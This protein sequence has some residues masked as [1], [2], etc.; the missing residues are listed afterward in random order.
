MT[1][2]A[3]VY[4][5]DVATYWNTERNPVNLRL[6]DV[7]GIYHH[8]Y[9]IGEVD[10]SV[11]ETPEDA[12]EQ[13]IIAELHRLENAQARFLLEHLGDIRPDHRLLD[14]GSGRGGSSIMANAA[15]GCQVDGVSISQAQVDFANEQAAKRGVSDRVRFHFRNMLDTG[16]EAGAFQA[17]WNNESTMYTVLDDLFAAHSRLL[18]RGGRYVTITGCYNDVYGLP[19]RAVSTINAHYVCDIHP[20][21]AYFRAM[22]A[23]RLVPVAVVD[24]TPDTIPYWELREKSSVATGIESAFLE[25]YRDGSFQ[26]LLIA[27][28][29]I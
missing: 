5:H 29:R 1:A 10:W 3:S 8:H 13:A 19:S 23:N 22:A 26:Y 28:D 27:A 21:S 6:G 17:V 15:F 25:A 14:A 16:F 7:S 4:Q 20:R 24:L 2:I 12:R 11:L 18:A 9:G